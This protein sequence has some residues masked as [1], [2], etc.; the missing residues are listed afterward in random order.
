MR[1]SITGATYESKPGP[2]PLSGGTYD[3]RNILDEKEITATV[4]VS[5]HRDGKTF[6]SKMSD[7]YTETNTPIFEKRIREIGAALYYLYIWGWY[8]G[9][10]NMPYFSIQGLLSSQPYT[11]VGE[12]GANNFA[13]I[14]GSNEQLLR[15]YRLLYSVFMDE[16]N[17]YFDTTNYGLITPKEAEYSY[18]NNYG[19][20]IKA[21]FSRA[22]GEFLQKVPAQYRQQ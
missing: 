10:I 21:S 13:E 1:C 8:T 7:I 17:D 12:S 3:G 6:H 15:Q 11:V 9:F 18:T 19:D 2:D 14:A 5:K 4:V 22:L 16:S 20:K